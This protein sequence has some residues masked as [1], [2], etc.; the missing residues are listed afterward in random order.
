M[1]S[2]KW[3]ETATKQLESA[4]I[5]S[6]RL[7]CLILLEDILNK[8]RAHLL[9]HPEIKL[10][11]EQQ[12][13]LAA[14]LKRRA[15]HEPLAYIRGRIEFFGRDF[16]VNKNVLVPRPES[17][18]M[19][20]LLKD[21][22]L[23]HP[24]IADIGTGSGAL[25]ITAALEIHGA[26]VDLCDID[27][28]ALAIASENC[29]L[30]SLDLPCLEE[31]LLASPARSYE[32]ILANLPYVPDNFTINQAAMIEPKHAIFGGPDGLDLYRTFWQQIKDMPSGPRFVLTES[33]PPQHQKLAEIAEKAGY[34]AVE[35]ADF[36]Q[37]FTT[38]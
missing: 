22:T 10:S 14:Q 27:P 20:E 26:Q 19:I 34:R 29:K 21:L 4:G 25:G 35:T 16:L 38:K 1:N 28:L 31:N 9:A 7:D 3:L 32:V 36:I 18:T 11:P 12:K 2:K 5:G 13:Q 24:K 37:L 30:H 23:D 8:D 17:E 15:G 6:A 33:L